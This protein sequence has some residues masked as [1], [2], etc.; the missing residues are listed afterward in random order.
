MN[1]S[2]EQGQFIIAGMY[3]QLLRNSN[4]LMPD[5]L[6]QSTTNSYFGK[7]VRRNKQY[8]ENR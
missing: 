5:N 1:I 7:T 8:I 6:M 3:F 4:D 2:E